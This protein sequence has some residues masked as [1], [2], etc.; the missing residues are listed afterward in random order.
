MEKTKMPRDIVRHI[1]IKLM[2]GMHEEDACIHVSHERGEP[3]E[4][5]LVTWHNYKVTGYVKD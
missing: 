5:V 2:S 1:C 3:L 4:K